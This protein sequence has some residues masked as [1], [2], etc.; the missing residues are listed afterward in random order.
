MDSTVSLRR[1]T[2]TFLFTDIEGYPR[3]LQEL[4]DRYPQAVGFLAR[5]ASTGR[6]AQ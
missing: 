1:A 2:V 5:P 4:S 3:L 6:S